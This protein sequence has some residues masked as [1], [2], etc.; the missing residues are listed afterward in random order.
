MRLLLQIPEISLAYL[1]IMP[2]SLPTP[3]PTPNPDLDADTLV[4]GGGLIALSGG[5]AFAGGRVSKKIKY[6]ADSHAKQARYYRKQDSIIAAEKKVAY[7]DL[8]T[9]EDVSREVD[10][11]EVGITEVD[12]GGVCSTFRRLRGSKI[13]P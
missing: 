4:L 3:S 13:V 8:P 1:A 6:S 12:R 9:E 10:T 5:I 7:S 2:D 11:S